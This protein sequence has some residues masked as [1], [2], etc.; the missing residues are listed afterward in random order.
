MDRIYESYKRLKI[1]HLGFHNFV[2]GKLNQVELDLLIG[3]FDAIRTF[4]VE[5]RS[6]EEEEGSFKHISKN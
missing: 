1:F 4:E 2:E 6:A 5:G 3:Y